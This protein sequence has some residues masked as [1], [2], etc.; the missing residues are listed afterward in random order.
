MKTGRLQDKVCIITGAARGI[1]ATTARVFAREGA[2]VTV[3]DIRPDLGNKVVDEIKKAGGRAIY[4]SCDVTKSAEVKKMVDA[5]V[6]EFGTIN[7]LFNNAGT[8]IEG[9]LNFVGTDSP[10]KATKQ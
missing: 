8:A 4:C 10:F 2:P 9:T 7:V 3:V 1:G 5:T 6:K